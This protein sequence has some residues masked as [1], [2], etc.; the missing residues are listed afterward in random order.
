MTL[1]QAEEDELEAVMWMFEPEQLQAIRKDAHTLLA[2]LRKQ[3]YE[4][5]EAWENLELIIEH[6]ESE[7]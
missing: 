4:L 5:L 6:L 2:E 3:G 1:L 7:C